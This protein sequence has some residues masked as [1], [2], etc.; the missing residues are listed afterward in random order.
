MPKRAA[1]SVSSIR[2]ELQDKE[3]DALETVATT[4]AVRNI[5]ASIE[6]LAT[7]LLAMSVTSGVIFGGVLVALMDKWGDDMV[8]SPDPSTENLVGAWL[9]NAFGPTIIY[10]AIVDGPEAVVLERAGILFA[11]AGNVRSWI[12]KNLED[13]EKE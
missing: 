6:S 10:D 13:K 1:D 9:I 8:T 5:A 2:I 11:M 12:T 7:P 3:R 4:M